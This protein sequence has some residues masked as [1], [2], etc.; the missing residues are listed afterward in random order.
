MNK[1]ALIIIFLSCIISFSLEAKNAGVLPYS[2]HKGNVYFLLGQEAFGTLEDDWADFGGGGKRN[3]TAQQTALRELREESRGTYKL[4]E[5]DL[6]P[7][8]GITNPG[9]KKYYSLFLAEVPYKTPQQILKGPDQRD[10][11][12]KDFRWVNAKH[13][14]DIMKIS[15]RHSAIYKS[16]TGDMKLRHHFVPYFTDNQT[17]HMIEQTIGLQPAQEGA[18][19]EEE[20]WISAEE[21]E[22]E[23]ELPTMWGTITTPEEEEEEEEVWATSLGER[24]VEF[25]LKNLKNRLENLNNA[26]K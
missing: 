17:R 1:K 11:E 19:S 25:S 22:S 5:K 24:S 16:R 13:F 9:P 20:G 6:Q 14:I 4:T 12:K 21:S 18:E 8:D 26:L 15:G 10:K 2:K 3:E 7:K 23:E